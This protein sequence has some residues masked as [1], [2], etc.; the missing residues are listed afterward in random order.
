MGVV[1]CID[2]SLVVVACQLSFGFRFV[3]SYLAGS[4]PFLTY[5]Y[6]CVM[7]YMPPFYVQESTV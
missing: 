3:K 6:M 5:V 7:Y 1:R 4:P 2:Y